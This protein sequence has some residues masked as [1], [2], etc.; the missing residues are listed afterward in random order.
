MPDDDGRV[1]AVLAQVER[2]S[3]GGGGIDE[4]RFGRMGQRE[5]ARR[6]LSPRTPPQDRQ[7]R[8]ARC[9]LSGDGCAAMSS[10]HQ[11]L[12]EKA[13]GSWEMVVNE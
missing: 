6:H 11:R 8:Q 13:E 7:A 12:G 4:R 2:A 5:Q 9:R 3:K 1:E 10:I